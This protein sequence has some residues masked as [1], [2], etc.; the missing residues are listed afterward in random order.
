[1]PAIIA[2]FQAA[3]G[4]SAEPVGMNP[5]AWVFMLVSMGGV[6]LLTVWSFARILGNREHFDPDGTGPASSPV[7][8]RYD[9]P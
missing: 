4:S 1:M 6:T 5:V 3:V 7:P 2:L 8:G 9:A